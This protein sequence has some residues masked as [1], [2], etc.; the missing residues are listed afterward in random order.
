MWLWGV[1]LVVD[2]NWPSSAVGVFLGDPKQ[3]PMQ[4][5]GTSWR[6]NARLPHVT[7]AHGLILVIKAAWTNT[8]NLGDCGRRHS[9]V[10]EMENGVN[11]AME[12]LTETRT[13]TTTGRPALINGWQECQSVTGDD[14]C[15]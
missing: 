13:L 15:F 10:E 1:F 14:G 9:G 6:S 11:L 7:L 4:C 3:P 5:F 2:S 12:T 8:G